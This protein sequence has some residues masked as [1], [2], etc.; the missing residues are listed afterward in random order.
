MHDLDRSDLVFE[1]DGLDAGLEELD[2]GELEPEGEEGVFDE[3]EESEL[4]SALLGVSDD[5]ELDQFLGDVFRRAARKLAPISRAVRGNLGGL[6]KG[7]IKK[8][9]P[10]F[11]RLA[12]GALGGPAGAMI[13]GQAAPYLSSLFGMELE[14]LSPEDQELESAKQLVRLAGSALDSVARAVPGLPPAA[15]A[16]RAVIE[17]ARRHAPGLVRAATGAQRGTWYRRGNAIVLVGA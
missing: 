17:A 16:R 2:D 5:H 8:S 15:A 9:L 3:V 13:A 1:S 7:A 10:T 6:L 4:A 11:A 14:G 12:G